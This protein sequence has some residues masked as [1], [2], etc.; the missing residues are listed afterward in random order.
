[1]ATKVALVHLE[2]HIPAARSLKDKRRSVKSFK[3][4]L[5][6]RYNVSV[7]EVDALDDRRRAV[8]AVVMVGNDGR[9]LES[10]MQRIINSAATQREMILAAEEVQWL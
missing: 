4:R 2:F 10:A 8:L 3:D 5:A 9:Y 6:N 1:M 7:A